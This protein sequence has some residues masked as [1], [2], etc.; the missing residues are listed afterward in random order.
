MDVDNLG[1]LFKERVIEP[2]FSSLATLS[3]LFDQ[4]F[5]GYIN[6][7]RD[8]EPYRDKVL[9]VYSGGDDLFAVVPG[10][11]LLDLQPK[12]KSIHSFYRTQ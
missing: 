10:M 1:L 9:I 8:Q 5:S 7:L 3:G 4:F 11:L 12:S 2:S 6:Y